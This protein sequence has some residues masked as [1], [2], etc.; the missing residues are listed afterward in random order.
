VTTT[1]ESPTVTKAKEAQR[2]AESE[3]AR[4]AQDAADRVHAA[5]VA[6]EEDAIRD[7][8]WDELVKLPIDELHRIVRQTSLHKAIAVGTPATSIEQAHRSVLARAF[9]EDAIRKDLRTF[10]TAEELAAELLRMS[11][12]LTPWADT[13]RSGAHINELLLKKNSPQRSVTPHIAITHWRYRK[14]SDN[15]GY[16]SAGVSGQSFLFQKSPSSGI[17]GMRVPNRQ[18]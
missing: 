4:A 17:V 2:K 18:Q 3:A 11:P 9:H 15:D 1:V 7:K 13:L 14:Q 10:S 5:E 16:D 8:F 6:A 12:D